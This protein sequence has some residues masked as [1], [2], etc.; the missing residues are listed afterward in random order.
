MIT[1]G[2]TLGE[3]EELRRNLYEEWQFTHLLWRDTLAKADFSE[4]KDEAFERFREARRVGDALAHVELNLEFAR[5]V[6][7]YPEGSS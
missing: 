2:L 6:A 4:I 1:E 5:L 3:L 7:E